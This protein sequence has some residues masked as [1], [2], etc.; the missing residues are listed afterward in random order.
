[1]L[2]ALFD[3]L[4]LILGPAERQVFGEDGMGLGGGIGEVV[5]MDQRETNGSLEEP[6]HTH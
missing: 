6:G 2:F 1:L 4:R 5:E 3:Q